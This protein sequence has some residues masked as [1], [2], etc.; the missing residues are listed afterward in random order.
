[1]GPDMY[2]QPDRII[3][4]CG[5]SN[6]MMLLAI[7]VLICMLLFLVACSFRKLDAR[8]P[9]VGTASVAISAVCHHPNDPATEAV[10]PLLW[11][12]TEKSV[13]GEPGHCALSSGPVPR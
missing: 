5:F 6:L 9:L 7:L 10:K 1:M 2:W 12:V 11:G 13:G 4:A 3:S 8:I